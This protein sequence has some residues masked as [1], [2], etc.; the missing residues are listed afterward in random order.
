MGDPVVATDRT[1]HFFFSTLSMNQ[2]AGRIDVSV[3]RS[4][5][6]GQTFSRPTILS[7][8][9]GGTMNDKPWM[10]IGPG[11]TD[12]S[13]DVVYVAWTEFYFDRRSGGLGSKVMLTSSLDLGATWLTPRTVATQPPFIGRRPAYLNG[14]SLAVDPST[15]RL[16]IAWEQF[17]DRLHGGFVFQIRREFVTSSG[18]GGTRFRRPVVAAQ[19]HRIGLLNRIC[20]DVVT[21]GAGHLVRVTEF[22]SLGVGPGGQVLLSYNGKNASGNVRVHVAR[23]LD[24]GATWARSALAGPPGAFMPAL[25]ADST[26]VSVV[27]YQRVPGSRLKTEITTSADGSSYATQDLSDTSFQVPITLPPF[28]PFSAPCY[29]GDYVGVRRSAGTAYTAWGDNRDIVHNA[30]WPQGRPDPDVFFAKL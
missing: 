4:N 6:G 30:F 2:Q 12:S 14:V 23:S 27:Y 15:G 3:G 9:R 7:S 29:M 20:G 24:G 26:G 8:R 17:V 5:D 10:A 19:P 16:Y 28:D 22:P 18:N 13:K 25:D 21:F 1:G 11:P